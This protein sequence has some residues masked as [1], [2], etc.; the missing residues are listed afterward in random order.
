MS[1]DY[2]ERS[3]VA[4]FVANKQHRVVVGLDAQVKTGIGLGIY[5]DKVLLLFR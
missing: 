3:R 1:F 5:R 4:S 2:S